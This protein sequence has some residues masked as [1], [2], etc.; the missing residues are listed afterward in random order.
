MDHLGV[1]DEMLHLVEFTYN[2]TYQ[3]SIG[4]APS[5]AFYAKKGRIPLCWYQDGET[6][7]VGP[8]LL[9]KATEKVKP[10]QDKM[11]S[12]QSKQ[13]SYADQRRKPLE[14]VVGD[15]VFM[16]VTPSKGVGRAIRSINC[17]LSLLGFIKFLER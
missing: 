8:E 4:M 3:A 17:L 9:Q 10:I 2:N 16:R 12:F 7:L 11:K 1:W 14:F 5:E 15:H 13:K 6:V